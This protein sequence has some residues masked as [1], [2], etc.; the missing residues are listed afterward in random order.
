MI[1]DSIPYTIHSR[2]QVS[3]VHGVETSKFDNCAPTA[4]KLMIFSYVIPL[5]FYT[6]RYSV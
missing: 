1:A 2:S 5:W 4:E 3:A 6:A